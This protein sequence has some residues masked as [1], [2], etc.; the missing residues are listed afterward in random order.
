MGNTF[1]RFSLNPRGFLDDDGLEFNDENV[2]NW[3]PTLSVEWMIHEANAAF[4][5][6]KN[7]RARSGPALN[8]PYWQR[9]HLS[10]VLSATIST[11]YGAKTKHPPSASGK[12][13]LRCVNV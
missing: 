10:D 1:S 2:N 11:I 9:P 13:G 8:V 7:D 12:H 4:H 5:N 3:T 6:T